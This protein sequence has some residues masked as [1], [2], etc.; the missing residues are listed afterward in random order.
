MTFNISMIGLDFFEN[1]LIC[2]YKPITS[3]TY[4]YRYADVSRSKITNFVN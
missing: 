4:I 2:K 3:P 1:V